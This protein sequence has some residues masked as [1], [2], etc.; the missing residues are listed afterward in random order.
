MVLWESVWKIAFRGA[1]AYLFIVMQPQEQILPQQAFHLTP[2][3]RLQRFAE[4]QRRAFKLLAA[5]PEGRRRYWERNLR[6]RCIHA[7]F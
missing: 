1:T 7:S 3:E 5:S 2:R 4:L 6:Q